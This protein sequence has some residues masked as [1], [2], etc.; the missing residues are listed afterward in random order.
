MGQSMGSP[1]GQHH[2][3]DGDESDGYQV[4]TVEEINKI[5][6]GKLIIKYCGHEG[7][8][9]NEQTASLRRL[10]Q[11]AITNLEPLQEQYPGVWRDAELKIFDLYGNGYVVKSGQGSVKFVVQITG[12]GDVELS[13]IKEESWWTSMKA[14]FKRQDTQQLQIEGAP[15]EQSNASQSWL[16]SFL[17]FWPSNSG[18]Q[19]REGQVEGVF[20]MV[21]GNH[22]EDGDGTPHGEP[23]AEAVSPMVPG[24]PGEDGDGTP[25]GG[26]QAEAVSPLVPG[27]HGENGDGTP[28]GEP[29]A[30]A[31][32]PM[33]P[34]NHGE[35]GDGTPHGEPQAEAVS[36]MVPGNHGENG[37]GTPHGEPQAEAVS[38]MVPGSPGE[39]GDGTPH[40]EPQAEA[41][42]PMV[43]GNHVV[44][45]A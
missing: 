33:V 29:Q 34:G 39:D 20:Q 11:R 23:Q 6:L 37:D 9:D 18:S 28:H 14:L 19:P 13:K 30:E 45:R 42:S 41:V 10:L 4:M 40:G 5:Q 38:P 32:S 21:P 36:P 26:P 8:T 17:S 27:N 7:T 24:S 31:V 15:P 12:K 1:E 16:S 44:D 43:P 2:Q 35:N 25:H 22:A 3:A